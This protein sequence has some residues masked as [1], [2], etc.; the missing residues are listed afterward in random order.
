MNLLLATRRNTHRMAHPWGQFGAPGIIAKFPA[1]SMRARPKRPSFRRQKQVAASTA[2]RRIQPG[3][4][5]GCEHAPAARTMG[6]VLCIF[7]NVFVIVALT[8][9][10]TPVAAA[11]SQ[12]TSSQASDIPAL[13]SALS[14]PDLAVRQHAAEQLVN[15]GMPA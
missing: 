8:L 10:C 15:I 4:K 6:P 12:E 11:S 13:I 5:R 1:D 7:L 3:A 14:D 2:K 9:A